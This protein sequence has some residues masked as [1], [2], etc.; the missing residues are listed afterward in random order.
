MQGAG[1]GVVSRDI[2]AVTDT[3]ALLAVPALDTLTDDQT[4]GA[5]C[6]WDRHEDR[7]TAE[8]AIGLGEHM[9]E[10]A[11]ATSDMRWFPRACRHHTG[12]AALRALHEHAPM[13]E[14]CVDNAANCET[15][16]ALRRIIRD[17]HR[18]TL[19]VV[20]RLVAAVL[21][22]DPCM[23]ARLFGGDHN[24]TGTAAKQGAGGCPCCGVGGDQ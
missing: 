7:L 8:T 16:R 12:Q 23:T 24:C 2:T 11:D 15:G 5:V 3:L 13:C 19:T 9:G 6:V 14:P 22:C 4:R 20:D 17:A 21:P 1:G 10:L 18:G